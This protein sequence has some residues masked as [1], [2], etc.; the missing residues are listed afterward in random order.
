MPGLA[1]DLEFHRQVALLAHTHQRHR[2]AHP[3]CQALHNAAALI[4]NA[5]QA[6]VMVSQHLPDDFTA[7][8]PTGFPSCP[9]PNRMVRSG[10]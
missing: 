3:A 2:P 9:K 6:D 5:C 7:C 4:H 1:V 10:R 8:I